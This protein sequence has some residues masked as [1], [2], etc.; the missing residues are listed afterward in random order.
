MDLG[1][2]GAYN[3]VSDNT[4]TFITDRSYNQQRDTSPYG[5]RFSNEI[6]KNERESGAYTR[7][8]GSFKQTLNDH[9][10]GSAS[11]YIGK[12]IKHDD[13]QIFKAEQKTTDGGAYSRNLGSYGDR[14]TNAYGQ[15]FFNGTIEN[16][17]F[18]R[19][20]KYEQRIHENGISETQVGSIREIDDT[21][22][23]MKTYQQRNNEYESQPRSNKFF[24]PSKYVGNTLDTPFEQDED[25]S[26]KREDIFRQ[27]NPTQPYISKSKNNGTATNTSDYDGNGVPHWTKM[28]YATEFTDG[29]LKQK[30]PK[31]SYFKTT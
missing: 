3:D 26:A 21:D 25:S 1:R 16:H 20:S 24:Q 18:T 7:F 9:H 8:I 29:Y 23:R 28:M 10:Q 11:K 27:S 13:E 31:V 19:G 5:E 6:E 15:S 2:S 4:R 22:G 14:T 17:D 30:W 12:S